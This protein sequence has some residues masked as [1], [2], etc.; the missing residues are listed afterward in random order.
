MGIIRGDDWGATLPY[1]FREEPFIP[2]QGANVRSSSIKG[3]D[4]KRLI[5]SLEGALTWRE[6][7]SLRESLL[8]VLAKTD[9]LALGLSTLS[10]VDLSFFQLV[11]SAHRSALLQGKSLSLAEE[12]V[13]PFLTGLARAA[14]FTPDK[15]C[16]EDCLL[17]RIAGG[18]VA[19]DGA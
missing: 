8:R 19:A 9:R 3:W 13:P 15:G 6:A 4:K 7:D 11:C 5:L 14:G 12:P 1:S 18:T 10:E 2:G 16:H 17:K